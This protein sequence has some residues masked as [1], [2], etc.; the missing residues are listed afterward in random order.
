MC[1][2]RGDFFSDVHSR[3]GDR[4]AVSCANRDPAGVCPPLAELLFGNDHCE[5]SRF[6][7]IRDNGAQ[8]DRRLG[9]LAFS[10]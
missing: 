4:T 6:T 2:N 5:L 7:R 9:R 8:W 1:S 3:H 10:A